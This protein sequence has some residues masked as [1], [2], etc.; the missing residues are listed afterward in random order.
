V[1][2]APVI[3]AE[4]PL[5][6][7]YLTTLERLSAESPENVQPNDQVIPDV[8]EQILVLKQAAI[9]ALGQTTDNNQAQS[10]EVLSRVINQEIA[11]TKEQLTTREQRRYWDRLRRYY[12]DDQR[13][14]GES[15]RFKEAEARFDARIAQAERDIKIELRRDAIKAIRYL[16]QSETGTTALC[17]FLNQDNLNCNTNPTVLRALQNERNAQVSPNQTANR[18]VSNNRSSTRT[19][20]GSELEREAP[21]NEKAILYDSFIE[22]VEA[23]IAEVETDDDTFSSKNDQPYKKLDYL[24]LDLL[25]PMIKA[26]SLFNLPAGSDS[27]LRITAQQEQQDGLSLLSSISETAMQGL[28]A[29][30]RAAI[31]NALVGTNSVSQPVPKSPGW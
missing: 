29:D 26:N 22:Q 11:I 17:S 20:S 12:T 27:S 16:A 25:L 4:N 19:I 21:N 6:R 30:S 10:L 28:H 5:Q 9:R 24:V 13:T 15:N 8:K 3:N 31:V 1:L 2:C 7:E 14:E 18:G 23:L